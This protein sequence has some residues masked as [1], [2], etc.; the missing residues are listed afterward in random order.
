MKKIPIVFKDANLEILSKLLN[1]VAKKY[2]CAVKYVAEENRIAFTGDNNCCR[3]VTEEM[4][5]FFP[6]AMARGEV[7]L[8]CPSENKTAHR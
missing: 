2:G 6:R 4:L 5:T 7:P 1:S 3:H 8:H